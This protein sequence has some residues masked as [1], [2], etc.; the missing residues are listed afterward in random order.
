MEGFDVAYKNFFS[1]AS[2]LYPPFRSLPTV[3]VLHISSPSFQPPMFLYEVVG[4][5]SFQRFVENSRTPFSR[6]LQWSVFWWALLWCWL[7]SQPWKWSC[8]FLF[9]IWTWFGFSWV[10]RECSWTH[11]RSWLFFASLPP[12]RFC[13]SN[14]F[15]F[16]YSFC[17]RLDEEVLHQSL[18]T[19]VRRN[20]VY[21]RF[22]S[23]PPSWSQAFGK[24]CFLASSFRSLL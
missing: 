12:C 23:F 18:S 15:L 10:C 11:S 14:E 16:S 8:S 4:F 5:S 2:R 13:C 9:Q 20:W 22:F 7:A 19:L 3:T 1:T 6:R 17:G 21:A 24:Y